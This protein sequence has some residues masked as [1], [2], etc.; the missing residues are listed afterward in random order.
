MYSQQVQNYTSNVS[1]RVH[2][3]PIQLLSPK[4][5]PQH[6]NIQ[7]PRCLPHTLRLVLVRSIGI[8][9]LANLRVDEQCQKYVQRCQGGTAVKHSKECQSVSSEVNSPTQQRV[10]NKWDECGEFTTV[11]K[12]NLILS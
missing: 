1:S 8:N 5:P 12:T 10:H 11:T 9:N 6:L 7:L 4:L 2:V 3:K